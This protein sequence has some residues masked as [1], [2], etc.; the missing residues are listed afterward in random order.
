[1]NPSSPALF[2][3]GIGTDVGKTVVA[4]ILAKALEADYWKPIQAGVVPGTDGGT[5]SELVPGV[6]VHPEAYRLALP[7]SPHAAA[8]AEGVTLSLKAILATRPVT[9]RPLVIEGAGGALVPLAPGLLLA[10]LIRALDVP[11][12]LVSRHYL[13]SINHTLLTVEALRARRIP[14]LGIVFNGPPTPASETFILKH[15]GLTALPGLPE[16]PSLTPAV[17][18]RHAASFRA[19]WLGSRM[20]G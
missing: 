9:S 15:T 13:G 6:L 20:V 8:E 5:I 14:I 7:V 12:V 17:I 11:V 2:V 1:M 16:E 4:A 18:S 10:D 3:T 19:W